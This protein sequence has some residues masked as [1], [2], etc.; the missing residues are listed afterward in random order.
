MKPLRVLYL[1]DSLGPGGAQRQL[2]TLV[3]A[4]DRT[5]VEANVAYY[6]PIEHFR[7]ELEEAGV[8]LHGLGPRAASRGGRDPRVTFRLARLIGHDSYD[9]VHSYL[10]TP[11]VLARAA[12]MIVT[13]TPMIVSERNLGLGDSRV[14]LAL[15]RALSR[16][17]AAMITNAEAIRDEVVHLVPAWDGRVH[18]VPNG[19]EWEEPTDEERA[20]AA[21][22]RRE[23][24][25]GAEVLLG[26]LGRVEHQKAPEVFVGALE[27]LPAESLER[28]RVVWVGPRIDAELAS[29]VESRVTQAQLDDTFAFLPATRESRSFYLGV[30]GV[31]MPSRW[32]GMPNVVLE[33]LAHGTPVVATDVG[34]SALLVEPPRAGWLVP[35]EDPEALATAI[36][37]L[38][39][40]PAAERAEMGARGACYVLEEFSA[41]RLADRTV[42]VYERVLGLRITPS[43]EGH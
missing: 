38:L 9:L 23:H 19:I 12:G 1:I 28:L 2:V 29:R 36:S 20:K 15:E 8:P 32:E 18:V 35:P 11:G 39:D 17:A 10:R 25:G 30:D 41:S 24:A 6:H 4:L 27:M 22:F 31:V 21:A 40:S 13:G 26:A 14:R 16:R 5:V 7:P 37:R 34:D 33:S 43:V 42:E 3:R